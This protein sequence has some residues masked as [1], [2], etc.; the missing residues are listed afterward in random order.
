MIQQIVGDQQLPASVCKVT[1]VQEYTCTVTRLLDGDELKNVRLSA[2]T[3]P[4]KGVLIRPALDSVVLVSELT[5]VDRFVSM[6]S[7]IESFRAKVGAMSILITED[8]IVFNEARLGSN[9]TDIAKLV[10]E[11][12]KLR[13]ELNSLKQVL[14][15][16][17]PVP[18][19]GGAVLKAAVATW[20][21]Q[22]LQPNITVN[23]LKDEKIKH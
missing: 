13:G 15:V 5:E 9:L 10:S 19:D 20:A 23:D 8:E 3:D 12:N 4:A 16:W 6:F 11:I 14:T 22:L 2:G 18:M 17:V 7:T 21:S 1:E